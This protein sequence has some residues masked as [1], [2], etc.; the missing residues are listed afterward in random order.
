M[1]RV[2]VNVLSLLGFLALWSPFM[3]AV[4]GAV[5]TGSAI[6]TCTGTQHHADAVCVDGSPTWCKC[7]AGYTNNAAG[8][9]VD[10]CTVGVAPTCNATDASTVDGNCTLGQGCN[11]DSGYVNI[12][13]G[14]CVEGAVCTGSAIGTCTGTQHHADAV[15][16]DGSPTW[17]KCA[18]GYTNNATGVCVEGEVCTGSAIGTCTGTQHHADAVC[19]DGNPTWCKCA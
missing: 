7:A 3:R 2:S 18:A 13:D 5:C 17:C 15:C 1:K 9:C 12:A 8:V 6:G 14:T 11:C 19:V 4:E 16:V 10:I